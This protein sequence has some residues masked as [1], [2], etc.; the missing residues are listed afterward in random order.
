MGN[1][2]GLIAGDAI[3]LRPEAEV[4]L[5]LQGLTLLA[6]VASFS[7]RAWSGLS[8]T[9]KQAATF[10]ALSLGLGVLP[11]LAT[12]PQNRMML[13]PGFGSMILIALISRWC[14]QNL[15][16]GPWRLDRV[17][18]ILVVPILLVHLVWS[19]LSWPLVSH[20]M[21]S[22]HLRHEAPLAQG[23]PGGPGQESLLIGVSDPALGFY[24]RAAC[25]LQGREHSG[26]YHLI[27]SAAGRHRVTRTATDQLRVEPLD[28]ALLGRTFDRLIRA[29][30]PLKGERVDLEDFS[31]EVGEVGTD[32]ISRIDVQLHGPPERFELTT[33]TAKG[34]ETRPLP[35]L[36]ESITLEW[37]RGPSSL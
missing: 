10:G 36:G 15:R 18:G 25:K 27:S 22:A 30:L 31:V 7:R 9:E 19:A 21:R 16:K 35:A 1:A 8:P 34:F 17:R 4:P 11:G 37:E 12:L 6:V 2:F 20:A 32:G 33:W 23:Q 29:D 13:L 26:G 14:W 5:A 24:F 28:G 3:L